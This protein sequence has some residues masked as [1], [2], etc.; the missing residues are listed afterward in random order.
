MSQLLVLR[1]GQVFD[2]VRLRGAAGV[3]IQDGK[4]SGLDPG[5]AQPLSTVKCVSPLVA[6]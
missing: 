6:R 1:A 5:G 3:L 4:I 2:G